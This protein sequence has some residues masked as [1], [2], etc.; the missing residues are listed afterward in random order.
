MK[1]KKLFAI[2]CTFVLVMVFSVATF[3]GSLYFTN[4]YIPVGS[5]SYISSATKDYSLAKLTLTYF[6]GSG[7]GW[8]AQYTNGAT[9]TTCTPMK[10][11][12][13]TITTSAPYSPSPVNGTGM[14][15]R[16]LG[17]APNDTYISGM[18]KF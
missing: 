18:A 15:I 14:R 6:N 17:E 12:Y 1:S 13:S 5:Y 4:K 7:F 8:S 3:A 2:I 10:Y 16:A 11:V 9:W